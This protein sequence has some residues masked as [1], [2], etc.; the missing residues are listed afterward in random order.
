V[1]KIDRVHFSGPTLGK[2]SAASPR[3]DHFSEAA[4]DAKGGGG[5]GD[6]RG[7]GMHV[8]CCLEEKWGV[9]VWT[10]RNS[11]GIQGGGKTVNAS[12]RQR[13]LV[14]SMKNSALR[15]GFLFGD[16]QSQ[17]KKGLS[18][19]GRPWQPKMGPK[20]QASQR[21]FLKKRGGGNLPVNQRLAIRT[22]YPQKD[23]RRKLEARPSFLSE[24]DFA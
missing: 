7:K 6:I 14:K 19:V 2:A 23:P 18:N 3:G 11:S 21:E 15:G 13:S 24:E 10:K 22:S 16:Q 20:N 5:P 8:R 12:W 4:D 1:E 9:A 17:V